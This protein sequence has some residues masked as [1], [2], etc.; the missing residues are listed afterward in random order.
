MDQVNDEFESQQDAPAEPLDP[1]RSA[2]NED[3]SHEDE[4]GHALLPP[5]REPDTSQVDLGPHHS[6]EP[7][8]PV[9]RPHVEA[10]ID[11]DAAARR[12]RPRQYEQNRTSAAQRVRH[13]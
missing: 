9:A 8:P 6:V 13:S 5:S 7:E 11:V 2:E 3:A 4:Q 10:D 1:L 12:A